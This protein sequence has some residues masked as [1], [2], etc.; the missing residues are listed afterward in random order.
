MYRCP[1]GI[2]YKVLM[3]LTL[4]TGIGIAQ[5]LVTVYEEST[6]SNLYYDG[7]EPEDGFI[8]G[9]MEFGTR[10]RVELD[11]IMEPDMMFQEIFRTCYS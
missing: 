8:V 6:P 10:M 4:G 9:R 1:M 2:V 11:L 3:S 5:S 7:A